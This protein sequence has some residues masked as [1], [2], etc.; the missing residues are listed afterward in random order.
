MY[1]LP[2]L[3]AIIANEGLINNLVDHSWPFQPC[4]TTDHIGVEYVGH[5]H[6]EHHVQTLKSG[7]L[8]H[9]HRVGRRALLR[10]HSCLS[11][12]SHFF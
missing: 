10:P 4:D 11:K 8:H 2:K 6:T 7:T 1:D 12:T 3:T 5:A 9:Q